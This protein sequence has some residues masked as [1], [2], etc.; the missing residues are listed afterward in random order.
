MMILQNKVLDVIMI[1]LLYLPHLYIFIL[2]S[3]RCQIIHWRK[4][5]K[6]ECHPPAA[7]AD[8]DWKTRKHAQNVNYT[9]VFDNGD[10]V[11]TTKFH[12]GP[13]QTH[14]E[15]FAELSHVKHNNSFRA[16]CYSLSSG[17]SFSGSSANNKT[18]DDSSS[19]SISSNDSGNS[20]RCESNDTEKEM[21][22]ISFIAKDEQQPE[23]LTPKFARLDDSV[24][25]YS[26]SVGSDKQSALFSD[27]R[28]QHK[29]SLDSVQQHDDSIVEPSVTSSGFWESALGP[30]EL[31]NGLHASLPPINKGIQDNKL[32]GSTLGFSFNSSRSNSVGE[33][34]LHDRVLT[35]QCKSGSTLVKKL[36]NDAV[37]S[38]LSSNSRK[39]ADSSILDHFS[40]TAVKRFVEAQSSA[41]VEST[42]SSTQIQVSNWQR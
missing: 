41:N 28:D 24:N 29:V 14:V 1:V 34:V 3:G 36:D 31:A 6:D 33:E 17:A 15:C 42:S 4:G 38:S 35:K 23:V 12:P 11:P 32:L 25:S 18:T 26:G 16:E 37:L 21:L 13:I 39:L 30:E 20:D 7:N 10:S 22:K 40:D 9:N 19:E 8:L 27:K 5:H 2:S